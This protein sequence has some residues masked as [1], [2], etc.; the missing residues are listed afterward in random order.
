[1]KK[2]FQCGNSTSCLENKRKCDGKVDC[3]DKS[4][5]KYCNKGKKLLF[6]YL[7]LKNLRNTFTECKENELPCIN[8]QCIP[9]DHFCDGIF[10]CADL[11]D[12]PKG[13]QL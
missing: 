6:K 1:M 9:K 13:C 7:S 2:N 11:S 12:E 5:E 10:Q 8:G 4:D 3:W